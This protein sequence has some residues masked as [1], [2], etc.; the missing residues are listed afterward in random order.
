MAV[1]LQLLHHRP[2][3]HVS[4][5]KAIHP[6]M[7]WSAGLPY[8]RWYPFFCGFNQFSSSLLVPQNKH[9]VIV[10]FLALFSLWSLSFSISCFCL[11]F[12]SRKSSFSRKTFPWAKAKKVHSV[13]VRAQSLFDFPML[14]DLGNEKEGFHYSPSVSRIRKLQ[15]PS[16]TT[17]LG[18]TSNYCIIEAWQQ[19]R[20]I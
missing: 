4:P 14:H 15:C 6:F 19:A 1:S 9:F 13:C 20:D 16:T 10:S 12:P 8:S 5:P 7:A 3:S 18:G 11:C 2:S 17:T